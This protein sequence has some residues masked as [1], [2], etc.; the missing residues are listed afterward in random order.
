MY[1]M[2]GNTDLDE[3]HLRH[4]AGYRGSRPVR[5]GNG[6]ADQLQLDVYGQVT[7]AAYDLLRRGGQL[8]STEL[9]LLAGFGG[10][11]LRRWQEP[12][13]GI[14]EYR[15]GRR[16]NTYSKVMCWAVLDRLIRLHDDNVVDISRERFVEG[17]EAIRR[18]IERY[19]YD[20]VLGSYVGDFAGD[21]MD[22]A[23]LL[24]A[25]CRYVEPRRSQNARHLRSSRASRSAGTA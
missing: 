3:Q 8:D 15:N 10:V 6:A 11:V 22:A 2:Y 23:L 18:S 7:L 16:H 21:T 14:W 9:R 19:G 5:M 4:L 17:R 1:D 20:E 25:R 12:D 24:M 13:E